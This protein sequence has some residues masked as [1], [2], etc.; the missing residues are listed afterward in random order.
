MAGIGQAPSP[1]T[2]FHLLLGDRGG[3]WPKSRGVPIEECAPQLALLRPGL[4]PLAFVVVEH[5][6]QIHT[7]CSNVP[8]W[9]I[10]TGRLIRFNDTD[11]RPT[12]DYGTYFCLDLGLGRSTQSL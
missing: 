9:G 1:Q 10:R 2:R 6:V 5:S 11:T 4:R 7:L 8:L 12:T 3:G